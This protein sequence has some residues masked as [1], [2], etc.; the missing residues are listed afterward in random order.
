MVVGGRR[1]LP[2]FCRRSAAVLSRTRGDPIQNSY[3]AARSS[4]DRK[5]TVAT[6]GPSRVCTLHGATLHAHLALHGCMKRIAGCMQ[7]HA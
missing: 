3:H 6:V 4:A 1:I 2:P 5:Y 7:A